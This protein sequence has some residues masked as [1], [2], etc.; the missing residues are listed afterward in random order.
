MNHLGRQFVA[1][2][3][4]LQIGCSD[5]R[6]TI[7]GPAPAMETVRNFCGKDLRGEKKDA[8]RSLRDAVEK[9]RSGNES[10]QRGEFKPRYVWEYGG[11]AARPGCRVLE[12]E[13]SDLENATTSIRMVWLNQSGTVQ[14]EV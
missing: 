10:D 3:C 14:G 4:L 13:P 1:T 5:A 9:I 11:S 8:L 6:Q 2:F 12:C 7:F